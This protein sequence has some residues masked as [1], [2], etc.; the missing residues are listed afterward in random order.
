MERCLAISALAPRSAHATALVALAAGSTLA[1]G[2]TALTGTLCATTAAGATRALAGAA[3]TRTLSRATLASAL[4]STELI[5]CTFVTNG[6]VFEI[7]LG[8]RCTKSTA[9]AG[10]SALLFARAAAARA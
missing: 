3:L 8:T 10:A 5:T 9:C 6:L 1:T 7:A 2:L 4:A